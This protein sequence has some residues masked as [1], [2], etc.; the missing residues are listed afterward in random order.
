MAARHEAILNAIRSNGGIV[1]DDHTGKPF[2]Y[3]DAKIVGV[4]ESSRVSKKHPE[5]GGVPLV[6]VSHIRYY[7]CNEMYIGEDGKAHV[8]RYAHMTMEP[9]FMDDDPVVAMKKF[10]RF[11]DDYMEEVGVPIEKIANFYPLEESANAG[12]C[13]HALF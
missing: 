9:Q 13:P 6:A 5:I 2:D 4:Y 10:N 1:I 8:S 3:K 12:L 11:A 7:S